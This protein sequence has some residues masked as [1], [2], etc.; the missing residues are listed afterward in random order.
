MMTAQ[1]LL[2]LS[3]TKPLVTK[4]SDGMFALTLLAFDRLGTHAVEPWRV[5]W[6]GCKAER[7]WL[8][9]KDQLKPGQPLTV[10]CE[11]LRNFTNGDRRGG[12]P[13]FVVQA[14]SIELAPAPCKRG[15]SAITAPAVTSY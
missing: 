7:F 13:E 11:K 12:G 10:R 3:H 6:S 4:A 15:E 8:I 14:T 2:F 9:F 1:G 5:T